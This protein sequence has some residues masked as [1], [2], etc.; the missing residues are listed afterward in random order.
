MTLPSDLSKDDISERFAIFRKQETTVYACG[1]YL[2]A[3]HQAQAK[4]LHSNN[5]LVNGNVSHTMNPS[6][7]TV[8]SSSS[9]S[10]KTGINEFWRE[11]ICEWSF[12]VIDHFDFSREIVSIS[13]NYL[14][15][16]LSVCIV[17][18]KKFQ[19]AAVT[20]IY[21]A[22]KL[23]GSSSLKISSFVELSRGYFTVDHIIAM[24]DSILR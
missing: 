13:L 10:S 3:E 6:E 14:D 5:N 23:Y 18:K 8:S 17:N 24:E 20:C 15:R 19:L 2:S 11:K 16:Y 7:F 9:S 21:I 12:Q 1:D 22:L 4:T